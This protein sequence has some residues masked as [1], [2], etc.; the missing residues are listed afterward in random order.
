MYSCLNVTHFMVLPSGCETTKLGKL[1]I[2]ATSYCQSAC[3]HGRL[4]YVKKQTLKCKGLQ[5]REER[6]DV[7]LR[8][9][10]VKYNHHSQPE[11]RDDVRK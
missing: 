8:T 1:R 11:D 7:P 5:K 6:N 2:A 9:N 3:A 4:V 10:S